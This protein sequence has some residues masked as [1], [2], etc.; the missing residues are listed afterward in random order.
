MAVTIRPTNQGRL[1]PG[2]SGPGLCGREPEPAK[3]GTG[4]Q[5]PM[6]AVRVQTVHAG[7]PKRGPQRKRGTLLRIVPPQWSPAQR[8]PT[9]PNPLPPPKAVNSKD[10]KGTSN[11]VVGIQSATRARKDRK[12]ELPRSTSSS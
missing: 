10:S 8:H 6:E 11:A 2:L 4:S 5:G 12:T 1:K 7:R 9:Q 3:R